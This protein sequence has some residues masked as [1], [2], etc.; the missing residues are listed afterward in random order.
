MPH[1][2]G[3][4]LRPVRMPALMGLALALVLGVLGLLGPGAGP[5][6]PA[7]SSGHSGS[8]PS[9]ERRAPDP[10]TVRGLY[11]DTR[12]AAHQQGP[13][14]ESIAKRAH[15]L[16]LGAEYYPTDQVAGVVSTYVG[17]AEAA[18]KTPM[19]VVYSI[20]DRDC[21]QYS[22]GGLPGVEAYKQWVA[23]VAEG[24]RGSSP[25]LVLEP[26]ALPFYHEGA[27]G[28]AANRV[29]LLR[30]A[31]RRLADAGAWVYIDAGH[32]GWT[33]GD[34]STDDTPW[35]GRAEL[36]RKAGVADARGFSTNVSNFRR[37]KAEHH[38]ARW[39]V[40]ELKRL[41]VK[42]T[43]YVVDTSRNGA[44]KPVDADVINPTWARLGRPPRLRFDGPFDGTLWVKHPG[45]SDGQWN[46][47]PASGQWCDLLA[48]RLLGKKE[49]GPGC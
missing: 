22:S 13:A 26:D 4:L 31:T 42:R 40:R 37:T 9:A 3:V 24:L 20:P 45:E 36:L 6:S 2:G 29:R 12:M 43:K 25:L 28:N 11:V 33:T 14:Y 38:Y 23:Q 41:G 27:C 19:L 10:R 48:D 8:L 7:A 44:R 32:S 35:D 17:L 18:D 46:G 15:A 16:W 34:T 47:G 30:W 5:A 1:P 21:G 39:L 49:P